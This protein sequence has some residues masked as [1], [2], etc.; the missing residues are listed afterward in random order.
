MFDMSFYYELMYFLCSRSRSMGTSEEDSDYAYID[1]STHSITG[2]LQSPT[3]TNIKNN[4]MKNST[5]FDA[6]NSKKKLFGE[7]HSNDQTTTINLLLANSF[8]SNGVDTDNNAL[9]ESD[10][11]DKMCSTTS[12]ID[13]PSPYATIQVLR[14]H[15]QHTKDSVMH[16]QPSSLDGNLI[17]QRPH[18][19]GYHTLKVSLT[20]YMRMRFLA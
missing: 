5:S 2:Y 8:D 6:G 16:N 18:P 7:A 3:N 10:I 12:F 13:S 1:R 11:V 9:E 14:K 15:R 19:G 4:L 17:H 20:L